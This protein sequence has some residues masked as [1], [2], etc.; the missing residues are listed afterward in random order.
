M[1]KTSF[2]DYL[3]FIGPGVAV[4]ATGVGAGDLISASVAGAKYG[5]VILWA[6]I[7]GAVLKYVLNEG[8]ARW[9]L[10]TQTTILE[11]WIA[12]LPKFVSIYFI[13]YLCIWAFVVAGALIAACG[14]AANAIFP[15]FSIQVWGVIH[16]LMGA[17]LVYFGRY[18]LFEKMM[19]FFIGI[20]FIT[21]I[22]CAIM[23]IPDAGISLSHFVPS[24]PDGSGKFLLGILGGVGGSVTLL[25]YGYW[26]RERGLS[27]REDF[28]KSK[29]D[30]SVA[31]IFTGLF[32]GAVLII[33]SG[34]TP[35]IMQ[36][37][38]IILEISSRLENIMGA[39]GKWIF[40]I[41][42]W[43]A[44]FTSLLGVWQ[45]VPY[46]F[47]DFVATYD[48]FSKKKSEP[49]KGSAKEKSNFYYNIF[50]F[51]LAV[52]PLLLLLFDRPSWI[53]VIYTITGSFFM[54]FLALTLLIMNNKRHW[55]GN[56]KNSLII[57]IFLIICLL[58]FM[59]VSFD[60]IFDL[61]S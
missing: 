49:E 56:F 2:L 58:V 50:L 1:K 21:F 54:P 19:K 35:E 3:K 25:S 12:K 44:V 60:E 40:M 43:G 38:K 36:G 16:S 22:Y 33:A 45:G 26:I 10:S 30:L 24:I 6:V 5:A 47:A 8:I 20:M 27:T 32:A 57:N 11:G 7:L 29:F 13:F 42:F 39:S 34:V 41:G 31:Y 23:V 59:Y 37:S 48:K 52:P 51:F 9:Q 53:I 14:I 28:K 4:A 61:F 55:V 18:S 46:I 15:E 17:M